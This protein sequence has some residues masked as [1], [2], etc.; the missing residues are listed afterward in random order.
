MKHSIDSIQEQENHR[1]RK[2][3]GVGMEWFPVPANHFLLLDIADMTLD[4]DSHLAD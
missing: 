2:G 1:T 3:L 4:P